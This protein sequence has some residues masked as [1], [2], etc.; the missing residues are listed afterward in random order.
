MRWELDILPDDVTYVPTRLRRTI[1][2]RD[3]YSFH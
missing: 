3:M 1:T 2:V